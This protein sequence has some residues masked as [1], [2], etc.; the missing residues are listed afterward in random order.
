M[1]KR[2]FLSLTVI[3]ALLCGGCGY[4]LAGTAQPLPF[5]TIAIKQVENDSYAAQASNPLTTQLAIRLSQSPGLE[6]VSLDDADAVLEVT[7]NDFTRRM[8]SS[9][10]QDTALASGYRVTLTA[11]CTLRDRVSG[12]VLFK[13]KEISASTNVY[14]RSGSYI[15]AEYQ[16]MTVLTD[17][18]AKRIV[19]QVLGVW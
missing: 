6:L 18:L 11:K 19:D 2:I 16:N 7:L 14:S 17:E 1:V 5:N 15:D 10:E 8:Y 12:K 3:A 13:D 9:Q 4:K